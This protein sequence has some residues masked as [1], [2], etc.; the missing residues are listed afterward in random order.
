AEVDGRQD[1][2]LAQPRTQRAGRVTA[3]DVEQADQRQGGGGDLRGQLVVLEIGGQVH[4]DESQLEAADEVAQRQQQVVAVAHGLAQRLAGAEGFSGGGGRLGGRARRGRGR[5][6][7]AQAALPQS[8]SQRA[9]QQGAGGQAHQGLGPAELVN[10]DAGDGHHEELPERA[11]G[12][13]DAHGPRA[14]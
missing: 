12:G 9:D 3:Q 5:H 1:P 13:R 8:E 6:G 14:L 4:A 11:G 2:V 7:G 10:Q